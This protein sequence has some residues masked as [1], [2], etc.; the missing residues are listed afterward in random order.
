MDEQY[1][2]QIMQQHGIRPTANRIIVAKAL[3][4]ESR[5]LSMVELEDRI[6]SID[7]SGIFRTLMLFKEQH[8]VHVIEEGEG[9]RYELCHSLNHQEDN[10]M[11]VHFHCERCGKTVCLE[12]IPVPEVALPDGYAMQSASFIIK[13]LCPNCQ[14]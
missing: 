14:K 5:P 6:G 10:D 1:L 2:I 13:G 8:L 11:H 9:T 3:V 7:K 4:E 12:N